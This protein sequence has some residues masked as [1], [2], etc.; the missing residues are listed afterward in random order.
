MSPGTQTMSP[1]TSELHARKG[2]AAM[3]T[4]LAPDSITVSRPADPGDPVLDPQVPSLDWGW[5]HGDEESK[6]GFWDDDL[7]DFD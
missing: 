7:T 5:D 1:G 4:T 6:I 3:A 2:I